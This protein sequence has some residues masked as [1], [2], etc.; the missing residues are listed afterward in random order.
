[1][2]GGLVMLGVLQDFFDGLRAGGV[3]ITIG[4]MDDCSR[5]L[6]LVEW[7]DERAF[8]TALSTTLVKEPSHQWI[9]ENLYRRFFH[10]AQGADEPKWSAPVY[11]DV[12]IA[13]DVAGYMSDALPVPGMQAVRGGLS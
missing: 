5:A 9:F 3:P 7:T 13:G 1:M 6:L 12:G 4:Q 8:H 2:V 11:R 10:A